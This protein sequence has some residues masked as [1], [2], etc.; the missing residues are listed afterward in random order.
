MINID[1]YA[2]SASIGVSNANTASYAGTPVGTQTVVAS[3]SSHTKLYRG[4][5]SGQT[6]N[7]FNPDADPN[8]MDTPKKSTKTQTRKPA[9]SSV[10]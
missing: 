2:A 1:A 5:V 9:T 7:F 10:K 3:L 6:T 4:G 8:D